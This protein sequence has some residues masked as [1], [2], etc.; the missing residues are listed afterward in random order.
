MRR[1]PAKSTRGRALAVTIQVKKSGGWSSVRTAH[2]KTKRTLQKYMQ[3]VAKMYNASVRA[4]MRSPAAR[5][6]P[7]ARDQ[8]IKAGARLLKRF[9]GHAARKVVK[10]TNFKTPN[11]VIAIGDLCGV[12]YDAKRDGKTET[13]IH[14]FKKQS[15]PLFAASHDGKQLFMLGGAYDFTERGIVDRT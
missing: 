13:Y 4:V 12:I 1:N 14:R 8:E 7:S 15:R 9:S 11:T 6:N 2:F 10:L 5:V 3:M